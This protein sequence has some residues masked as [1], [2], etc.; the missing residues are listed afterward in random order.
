M[1]GL[2]P[3]RPPNTRSWTFFA[4]AGE[5]E[6]TPTPGAPA[7][8]RASDRRRMVGGR[9]ELGELL[10]SGGSSCVWAC[11]NLNAAIKILTS[12]DEDARRR[13]VDEGRLLTHL[14]HPHLVQVL[15]VGETDA[16]APFMVL[17][18]LSGENLDARLLR[19]GPLHWLEV[20]EVMTQVAG[21]LEALHRVGVIHRDVKPNNI[22]AVK[23]ATSRP[24]V[25]LIDLG[26]AKVEDWQRIEVA[27]GEPVTRHQTE[28]GKL[29][30]TD[31]F[32]PPEAAL[33]R[34]NPGFDVFGL[35]ATIYLLCT[36]E[37]PNHLDYRPMR[38]VRPECGV[39]PE[40]EALVADALALRPE[41][42]IAGVAEF[43]RRLE[44]VR[45]AHIEDGSPFLFEGCYELIELL[46]SGAK[47]EVHRAY[48][49]DAARYVALKILDESA[50]E[51][52]EE[53]LRFAREARA[54]SAVQ[55]PALPRLFECRTARTHRRPYLVMTLMQGRPARDFYYGGGRLDPGEVIAIGKQLAGALAALHAHGI[56]H[57]D[58]HGRNVL[59]DLGRETTAALID[60]GMVEFEAKFYA[61]VAQRYPTPPE[62]RVKLGTGGL[63]KMDWTAPEARA[64]KGWTAKSDVFSLGLLLYQLLSGKRPVRD[65]RN[66]WVSPRKHVPSCPVALASALL[67]TLEDDPAA[68]V[69]MQGLIRKLD[70]AAEE[71]A[72]ECCEDEVEAEAAGSSGTPEPT[73]P[74]ILK[75]ES[76]RTKASSG[77]GK[78][79]ATSAPL[80]TSPATTS[81]R[82][83]VLGEA[84]VASLLCVVIWQAL[85]ESPRAPEPRVILLARST[86]EPPT[87]P[88]S[89]A[90][91]ESPTL[92][93]AAPLPT[94]RKALD[95]A[96]PALR[97]CSELAGGLLLV[98]FETAENQ[99]AFVKVALPGNTDD[100]V[101]RCVDDATGKIRF[102]PAGKQSFSEEY[103]P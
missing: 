40:L 45:V 9:F 71:W 7:S 67:N 19:E 60:C 35:G 30:G 47:G 37:L 6:P 54:L 90:T 76:T 61:T 8:A 21:A 102:A 23:S 94:V 28:L 59:L 20:V 34:P 32:I 43:Q 48:D 93:E 64:G 96:G 24:F 81:W 4:L 55:H 97:R 57:R 69:D 16:K 31:G 52:D 92:T 65:E 11:K 89:A 17:E 22:V 44:R 63:E 98:E 3:P 91:A 26:G 27:D 103:M 72:E 53:R 73:A 66:Q 15:A 68:R 46:G 77:D 36:G 79:G 12:A 100:A 51:D 41:D 85:R 13:F 99:P 39:P 10:G 74:A 70:A 95:D 101:R 86:N 83:A 80:V 14:R 62:S 78:A 82:R 29:V 2:D 18:R 75:N 25:K 5:D 49:R 88:T 42:R 50:R 84:L 38:E 58:V 33:V 1:Q 56:V 87:S